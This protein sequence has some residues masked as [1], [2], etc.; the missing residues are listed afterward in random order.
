MIARIETKTLD[1]NAANRV[2]GAKRS[3][4]KNDINTGA[5]ARRDAVMSVEK[6]A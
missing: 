5:C 3:F 1:S 4:P 2:A 6:E